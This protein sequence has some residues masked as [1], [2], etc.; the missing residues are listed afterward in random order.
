M[1]LSLGRVVA[2]T[3]AVLSMIA[4]AAPASALEKLRTGKAI[5]LPFDFTPLDIG[6]AKGFFQ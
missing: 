2:A 4:V 5:A 3:V 1:R 6:T